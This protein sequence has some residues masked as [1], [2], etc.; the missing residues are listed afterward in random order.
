MNTTP[1]QQRRQ[2]PGR[3]EVLCL[4][5]RS[6]ASSAATTAQLQQQLVSRLRSPS[7]KQRASTHRLPS[8]R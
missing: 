7:A 1:E 4:L 2:V 8:P 3:A 6:Q 5:F